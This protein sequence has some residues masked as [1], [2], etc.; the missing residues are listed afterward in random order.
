[1]ALYITILINLFFEVWLHPK[2]LRLFG[3]KERHWSTTDH[4][5]LTA[6]DLS[7][8]MY[9]HYTLNWLNELRGCVKPILM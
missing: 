7:S 1:M 9:H 3:K 8:L 6:M 4:G 5:W 2:G